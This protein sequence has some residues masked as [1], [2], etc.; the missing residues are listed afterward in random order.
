MFFP[1]NS[2]MGQ[3]KEIDTVVHKLDARIKLVSLLVLVGC[4]FAWQAG[5]ILALLITLWAIKLSRVSYRIIAKWILILKWF[6][7][8]TFGFHLFATPGHYIV[9]AGRWGVT[10]EGLYNG[11]LISLRLI[12]LL[13]ASSLLTL[14]TSPSRLVDGLEKLLFPFSK[15]GVPVQDISMMIMLSLHF[16]PILWQ[17]ADRILKA[18]IAR[19]INFYKGNILQRGRQLIP[20]AIPLIMGSFRRADN[21]ALA[22]EIRHYH[23]ERP[24]TSLYPNTLKLADYLTLA[25]AVC[26]PWLA[27]ILEHSLF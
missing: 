14:T 8:F 12:L 9:N 6:L 2:A 13:M 18:Q 16:I 26:L 23:S 17:E 20:M 22:M 5:S 3:Y 7:I 11:S 4:A 1:E 24:R 15:I 21:L 19:G 10:Y 25:G 27:R